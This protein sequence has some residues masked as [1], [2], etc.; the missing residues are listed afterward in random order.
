[1]SGEDQTR[2]VSE[3]AYNLLVIAAAGGSASAALRGGGGAA[4]VSFKVGVVNYGIAPLRW[5]FSLAWALAGV[6]AIPGAAIAGLGVFEVPPMLAKALSPPVETDP[7][8]L[9][10]IAK[11]GLKR[12]SRVLSKEGAELAKAELKKLVADR[13][14]LLKLVDQVIQDPRLS[15]RAR[16]WLTRARNALENALKPEDLIGALRDKL[17]IPVRTPGTGRA[18]DHAQEV[19]DAIESL[20]E[21]RRG[22]AGDLRRIS[23]AG[24]ETSGL[25]N[26]LDAILSFAD[27]V[28]AFTE[29][30]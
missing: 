1:M 6:A 14:R 25:S 28:D 26:D 3:I 19:K 5:S 16:A 11:A 4:G 29:I 20:R 30:R 8:A 10:D 2:V 24:H 15:Q 12:A 17:G 13:A 27:R 9:G 23:A 21:A 7:N 18:F 22:L